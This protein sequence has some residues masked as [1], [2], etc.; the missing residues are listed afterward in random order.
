MLFKD[1]NTSILRNLSTEKIKTLQKGHLFPIGFE[2]LDQAIRN[3]GT[4]STN[5]KI[6]RYLK[7]SPQINLN[8]R[9]IYKKSSSEEGHGLNRLKS[10]KT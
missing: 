4:I 10:R 5:E 2:N 1:L 9:R 7:F 3:I 8:N 6:E